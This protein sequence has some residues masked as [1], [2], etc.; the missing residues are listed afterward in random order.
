METALW[1]A[2]REG[3]RVE[4]RGLHDTISSTRF[5]GQAYYS[6]YP[7][8]GRSFSLKE[9]AQAQTFLKS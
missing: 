1:E 3:G 2:G 6:P 7:L 8:S 4:E 5:F 9:N